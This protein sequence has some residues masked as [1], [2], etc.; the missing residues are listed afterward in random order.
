MYCVSSSGSSKYQIPNTEHMA[1]RLVR[2]LVMHDVMHDV[3]HCVMRCV[4]HMPSALQESLLVEQDKHRLKKLLAP[5]FCKYD[6][7]GDGSISQVR[8]M[9]D[10]G[11][12]QARCRRYVGEV[13]RDLGEARTR[14]GREYALRVR[15]TSADLYLAD[16]AAGVTTQY[17]I[18]HLHTRVLHYAP[19]LVSRRYRSSRYRSRSFL[20]TLRLSCSPSSYNVLTASLLTTSRISQTELLAFLNDLGERP[21]R[22]EAALWMQKLDTDNTGT[23]EQEDPVD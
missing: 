19:L 20:P 16:R 6:V 23:I 1:D 15:C 22:A 13:R 8:Y 11:E 12:M 17:G 5:F 4:M 9:R 3:M 7:D 2:S 14:R 18:V 21:T 10:V